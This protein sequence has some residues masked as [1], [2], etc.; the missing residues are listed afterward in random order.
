MSTP[1]QQSYNELENERLRLEVVQLKESLDKEQF[2]HKAVYQQWYELNANM[3]NK[4]RELKQAKAKN[5]LY[6]YT[7]YLILISLPI[8]YYLQSGGRKDGT[9]T[10]LLNTVS[11]SS[12]SP[13]EALVES[14][15][16]VPGP[17]IKSNKKE[18]IEATEKQPA[19]MAGAKPV[20]EEKLSESVWHDVFWEGWTAYYQKSVNPYQKTSQKYRV[21]L[22]GW[23]EGRNDTKNLKAKASSEIVNSFAGSVTNEK[24]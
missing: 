6:K 5:L 12:V 18:V 16:A 14:S 8:A 11:P 10:P 9:N 21:W 13:N 24:Q 23:E 2:F 15:V 20:L 3:L 4:E 17:K 22:Q 19:L 1:Q 7:F